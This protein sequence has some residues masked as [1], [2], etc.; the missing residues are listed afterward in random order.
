[1]FLM[2]FAE[3]LFFRSM[4]SSRVLVLRDGEIAEFDTP[5]NLLQ[6]KTS[7]FFSMAVEAGLAK[8]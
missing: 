7:I 8:V 1:M 5:E 2:A 6:K 4:D 3:S